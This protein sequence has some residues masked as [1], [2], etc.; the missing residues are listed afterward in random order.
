MK[1]YWTKPQEGLSNPEYKTGLVHEF[2]LGP[3][4]CNLAKCR[5]S[6]GHRLKNKDLLG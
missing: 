6:L 2:D 3:S 4:I 1:K 5:S